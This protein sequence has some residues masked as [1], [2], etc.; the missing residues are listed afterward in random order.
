MANFIKLKN[1]Y[2]STIPNEICEVQVQYL[3]T[4]NQEVDQ[5]APALIE[6]AQP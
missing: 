3:Y 4:I 5:L 2:Y 6:I 1:S